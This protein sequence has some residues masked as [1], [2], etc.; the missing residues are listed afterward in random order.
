MGPKDPND[1]TGKR[2]KDLI[3]S[4]YWR[5]PPEESEEEEQQDEGED[6]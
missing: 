1:N 6:D 5:D 2:F 3:D 4:L